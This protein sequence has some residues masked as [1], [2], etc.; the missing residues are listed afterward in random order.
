MFRLV[1]ESVLRQC[2]AAGRVGGEGFA[3]DASVIEPAAFVGSRALPLTGPTSSWRAG[4]CARLWRHWR[5][6]TQASI[7]SARATRALAHRSGRGL[8]HAR[9]KSK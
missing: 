6:R 4:R 7:P 8:D 1:F 2:M 9:A 5:A 3:V